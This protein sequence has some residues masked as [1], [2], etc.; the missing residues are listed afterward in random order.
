MP[1]KDKEPPHTAS[2]TTGPEDFEAFDEALERI[3]GEVHVHE[4]D[5]A[6]LAEHTG[7]SPPSPASEGPQVVQGV[8]LSAEE[9]AAD[10][11]AERSAPDLDGTAVAELSRKTSDNALTGT[12]TP[13]R[14][15]LATSK[16]AMAYGIPAV[17]KFGDDLRAL[18][19]ARSMTY[20]TLK[21]L[22]PN[23]A[24]LKVFQHGGK[25]SLAFTTA[26][27]AHVAPTKVDQWRQ[28]WTEI[29][30]EQRR[31]NEEG[32]TDGTVP[33]VQPAGPAP[34]QPKSR[35]AA[36]I[37][38][39]YTP[40]NHPELGEGRRSGP[41]PHGER[42]IRPRDHGRRRNQAGDPGECAAHPADGLSGA[43]AALAPGTEASTLERLRGGAVGIPHVRD[44]CHVRR[45]RRA[46]SRSWLA[47][48]GH[49][50]RALHHG[51][52]SC[53]VPLQETPQGGPP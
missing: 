11:T 7:Q 53:R 24:Q 49:R 42:P 45:R 50:T 32:R 5:L 29:T 3:K 34:A 12:D 28:R 10:R 27:V 35:T 14:A 13:K 16:M 31:A 41:D 40:P 48:S 1:E 38:A 36:Q 6:V 4:R 44:Y 18:M 15:P 23:E 46:C 20:E 22:A 17:R 30:K 39:E 33:S 52:G 51:R 19:K 8:V 25:P 43:L 47:Q 2:G 21:E 9:A 37:N 26:I